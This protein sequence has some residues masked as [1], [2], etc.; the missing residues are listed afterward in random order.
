MREI[1]FRAFQDNE[2]LMSP[3]SSNYGLNRFFGMLSEDTKIMQYIGLQDKN[4]TDIYEGDIVK[5]LKRDKDDESF[6]GLVKYWNTEFTTAFYEGSLLD[7]CVLCFNASLIEI[8]GN[9][10]E[11]KELLNK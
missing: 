2:M 1:K 7:E 9:I 6:I 8:I 4:G 3:I 5:R 10:H 11:N